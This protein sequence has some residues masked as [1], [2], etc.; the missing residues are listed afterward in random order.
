[1]KNHQWVLL[2]TESNYENITIDEFSGWEEWS[3]IRDVAVLR[4]EFLTNDIIYNLG[5][6]DD[7]ST[8][9]T[10]PDIILDNSK[11]GCKDIDW[12]KI[13][14]FIAVVVLLIIFAPV[15]PYVLRFIIFIIAL[16][17]K[18]I[19]ALINSAKKNKKSKK[20]GE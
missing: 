2:F 10:D 16:P 1:M 9:D 15:L 4:L 11:G 14:F 19:A 7:M 5:V 18:G 13:L 12:R 3:E 6:V 20:K 17:F 8:P